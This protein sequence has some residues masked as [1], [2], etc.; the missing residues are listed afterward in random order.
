MAGGGALDRADQPAQQ[1]GLTAAA[2]RLVERLLDIGIDGKRPFDSARVA[3]DKALAEHGGDPERAIK[4]LQKS[5]RRLGA[6]GGF[7]TG[8]G[9]FFL[10]PVSLPVNVLEFHLV[11]TR[12]VA[13][14]AAVRGYDLAQPKIRSAVLLTLVG[15]DSDD[16]L[17]KAGLNL[18]GGKMASMA[19]DRLPAPALMV[20]NKA[21]G[22]R[23]LSR[24]GQS[25]LSRLGRGVPVAGGVIG[26]ALDVYLLGRIAS[27]ARRE[28]P[29]VRGLGG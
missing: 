17:K 19:L 15:A 8:V 28:F 24:I 4:A 2:T 29:P 9:G 25:A 3:A 14:I 7:A 21:V 10:L 12:L 6:A 22:F 20:L 13:A 11:A 23:L 26:G 5:H 16:L 18:A 1:G 27:Q